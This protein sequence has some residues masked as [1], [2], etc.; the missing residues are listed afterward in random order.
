MARYRATPDPGDEEGDHSMA[1]RDAFARFLRNKAESQRSSSDDS[2]DSSKSTNLDNL[3]NDVASDDDP[4][5][6]VLVE[7]LE[8]FYDPV[9]DEF[10]PTEVAV[11]IIEGF[12]GDD[13]KVLVTTLG[14][15]A[16]DNGAQGSSSDTPG[17]ASGS[18]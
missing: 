3:A 10:V 14:D 11:E 4:D 1:L 8:A 9:T 16:E 5:L 12:D 2:D 17:E 18:A 6:V 15:A 7:R 13:P